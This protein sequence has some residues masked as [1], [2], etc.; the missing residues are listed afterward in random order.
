MVL[1]AKLLL[2]TNDLSLQSPGASDGP[3]S[4]TETGVGTINQWRT[5]FEFF[6]IPIRSLIG[7]A[8]WAQGTAVLKLASWVTYNGR[9]AFRS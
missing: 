9:S 1:L 2:R 4:S 3:P 8:E 7:E 6:N 5:D